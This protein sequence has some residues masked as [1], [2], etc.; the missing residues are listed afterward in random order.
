MPLPHKDFLP[1][2]VEEEIISFA[3]KFFTKLDPENER[4]LEEVEKHLAQYGKEKVKK[5]KEW[6]KKYKE[7]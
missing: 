7:V 6:C 3:D 4:S 1:E 5:F 2:T